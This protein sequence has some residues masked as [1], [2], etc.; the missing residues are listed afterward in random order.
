MLR[1]VGAP[2]W[3]W[4][5][6]GVCQSNIVQR[7][8]NSVSSVLLHPTCPSAE[9]EALRLSSGSTSRLHGSLW[10]SGLRT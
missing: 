1:R 8:C 5:S 4:K 7:Q 2:S 6:W 10:L 3:L 9:A